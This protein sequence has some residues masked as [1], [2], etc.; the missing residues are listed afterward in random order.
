MESAWNL[1]SS[2]KPSIRSRDESGEDVQGDNENETGFGREYVEN[3]GTSSRNM[4]RY[5]DIRF[6]RSIA[7]RV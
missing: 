3:G 2:Q 4:C 1:G 6:S 5:R 7:Y